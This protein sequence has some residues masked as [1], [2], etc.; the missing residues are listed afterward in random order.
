[1][2]TRI[3]VFLSLSLLLLGAFGASAQGSYAFIRVGHFASDAPAVDVYLNGQLSGVQG[4]TLGGLTPWIAVAPGTYSVDVTVAGAPVENAV[5]SLEAAELAADTWATISAVGSLANDS[6]ALSVA[7]EDY[8]NPINEGETRVSLFHAIEGMTGV[9]LLRNGAAM[10]STVTYPQ[11]EL[12]NDGY[13]SVELAAA[14]TDFQIAAAGRAEAVI[15]DVPAVLLESGQ[16]VSIFVYGTL[17]DPL[18]S[19]QT[20]TPAEVTL[21]EA[22]NP[23]TTATVIVDPAQMEDTSDDFDGSAFVRVGHFGGDAPE[24]DIYLNGELS[25]ITNLA[26]GTVTDWV[27]VPA[28]D[29]VIDVRVAGNPDSNPVMSLEATLTADSWTTVSA[30]GSLGADTLKLAAATEDYETVIAEG[31]TRVSVFHAMEGMTGIDL[32]RNGVSLIDTVAFPDEALGN[33][34]QASVEVAADTLDLQITAAGRT[35]AVIVTIPAVT[36]EPNTYVAIFVYGTLEA[37]L[38]SVVTTNEADVNLLRRTN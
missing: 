16:Y 13:A 18:Y 14:E 25:G 12:G 28:G 32:V 22:G 35:D 8:A 15:V 26:F 3:L 5:I 2:R 36:L 29:Y 34:G 37:P 19:L 10:L 30:L 6:L 11:P 24:V 4:L 23:L 17:Q 38:Y 31:V 7:V 20:V 27:A 1:M 21:V 33:D 9:D